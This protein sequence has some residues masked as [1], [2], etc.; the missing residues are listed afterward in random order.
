MHCNETTVQ[1]QCYIWDVMS[2]NT[3]HVVLQFVGAELPFGGGMFGGGRGGGGMFGRS[4]F[5]G[6]RSRS[7]E[8]MFGGNFFGGGI[9]SMGGPGPMGGWP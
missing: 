9:R 6:G 1:L 8:S 2:N 3:A 7:D 5:G 4:M